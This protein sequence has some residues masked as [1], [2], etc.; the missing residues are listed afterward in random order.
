M[1]VEGTNIMMTRG[2]SE[3]ITISCTNESG[4]ALPF[5]DGDKIYFTVKKGTTDADKLIQKVISTFTGGK[6]IV[7]IDPPD[8]KSLSFGSYVYDIQLN[9]ADGTVTTLV[10]PSTFSI[11]GEVTYE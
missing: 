3:S 4:M 8:T 7:A 9:R 6:A 10:T 1:I 2:D 11:L 5:V